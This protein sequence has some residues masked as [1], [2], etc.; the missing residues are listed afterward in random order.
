M[1]SLLILFCIIGINSSIYSQRSIQ[2]I[3][4]ENKCIPFVE[5][6][7]FYLSDSIRNYSTINGKVTIDD[8][9]N[10]NSI[11]F[12][13]VSHQNKIVSSNELSD[14]VILE[15]KISELP[16]VEVSP[17]TNKRHRRLGVKQRFR[18]M[19]II[20]NSG[21]EI[22]TLFNDPDLAGWSID[23]FI[24]HSVEMEGRYRGY[25]RIVFYENDKGL[26]S[27]RIP[28]DNLYYLERNMNN[29]SSIDLTELNI[30]FPDSGVF[31]GIEWLGNDTIPKINS[32]EVQYSRVFNSNFYNRPQDHP[33]FSRFKLLDDNWIRMDNSNQFFHDYCIPTFQ[34]I[35][36]N[37]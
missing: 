37:N 7:L 8:T 24:F 10:L 28:I 36:S 4:D 25:F 6:T 12:S 17:N 13:H 9:L 30:T 2:I 35:L 27:S 3:D 33:S 18:Q 5:I 29:K 31:V 1:K 11:R 22:I 34:L 23:E 14:T 21:Y 26:P 19:R 16:E 15:R 20:N 32:F